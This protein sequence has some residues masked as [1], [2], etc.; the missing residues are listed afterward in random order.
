MA[1]KRIR[2]PWVVPWTA[3]GGPAPLALQRSVE[4]AL[5]AE[6]SPNP[7]GA[8]A[9][10]Q[11]VRRALPLT[12]SGQGVVAGAGL[13]AVAIG[14]TGELATPPGHAGDARAAGLLRPRPAAGGH[15]DRRGRADR[16][17]A[18]G[19]LAR[20]HR[21]PRRDHHDAQRPARLGGA[22]ADRHPAAAG[23][24]GRA[25]WL[26]P[27]PPPAPAGRPLGGLDRRRC[28]RAAAGL[29]VVARARADRRAV[30]AR[31]ARGARPL[32]ARHGRDRRAGLD[33]DHRRGRLVRRAAADRAAAA[34][35]RQ[36]RGGR[37]GRR[38]GARG[39][40]G[41]RR[42]VAVQPLRGGAAAARRAPVAVR[43]LTHVAPARPV[44][45]AAGRARRGAAAAGAGPLRRRVRPQPARRSRGCSRS[46][47]PTA[48][49][50]SGPR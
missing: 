39:Q 17:R 31:D 11:W 15:R 5:R 10:G 4:S 40:R 13:P 7:G 25:R 48:T 42:R 19:P 44:G 28:A 35:R 34:R 9:S 45:D 27:R 3:D 33:G 1:G 8:H 30:G 26:V 29:A 36:R 50:R 16:P 46:R 2:K 22:P 32:P 47:R 41:R 12:L 38:H 24:A 20:V 37:A 6:V 43:G 23:A 14:T 49:S 21:R 18:G